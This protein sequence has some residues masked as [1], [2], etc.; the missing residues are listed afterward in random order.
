MA[1]ISW[2]PSPYLNVDVEMRFWMDTSDFLA[3]NWTSI[4][5]DGGKGENFLRK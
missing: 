2:L 4:L 5:T 1:L 3:K